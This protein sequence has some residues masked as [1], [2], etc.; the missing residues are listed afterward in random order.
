M[1]AAGS[2][3]RRTRSTTSSAS[4]PHISLDTYVRPTKR[5]RATPT[6]TEDDSLASKSRYAVK[7]DP[8]QEVKP[9]SKG[10]TKRPRAKGRDYSHLGADPLTDRIQEGLDV[11]FC[12]ENPGIRTAETQLHYA[13][14]ANHF[15]KAVHAAGLTPSVLDPSASRTFPEDHNVGITNL[16]ARPTRE[17]SEL[18][19]VELEA[20]VPALLQKV[21]TYRPRIV[22]FV[23]MKVGDTVAQFLA[24]IAPPQKTDPVDALESPPR[25]GKRTR[26]APPVKASIGLQPFVLSH[27]SASPAVTYFYV[28]PSTSGRVAAYPLPVKLKL[29]ERFGQEVAKLRSGASLEVPEATSEFSL[30]QLGLPVPATG[31]LIKVEVKAEEFVTAVG[32]VEA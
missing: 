30:E 4:E 9:P 21:A 26:K 7:N 8:D 27:S 17:T 15:Y 24:K 1:Q 6:K 10:G 3:L 25:P 5:S 29:F 11:L 13:S 19:K 28:L 12:G 32:E 2:T 14:P 20:A 16:V 22:A 18:T 23:G 31:T